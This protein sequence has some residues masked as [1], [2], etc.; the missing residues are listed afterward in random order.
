MQNEK[1]KLWSCERLCDGSAAKGTCRVTNTDRGTYSLPAGATG[2]R[3]KSRVP[4]LCDAE[5]V[6]IAMDNVY[7]SRR[8]KFLQALFTFEKASSAM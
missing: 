2:G 1:K 6:L 4:L 8:G 5:N 3:M 7:I